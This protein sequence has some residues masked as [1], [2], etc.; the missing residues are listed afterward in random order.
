MRPSPSAI[1]RYC[2]YG[3]HF[4]KPTKFVGSLP[5]LETLSR[6]RQGGHIHEQLQ[7][8]AQVVSKSYWRTSLAA[9]YP[10]AL[11]RALAKLVAAHLRD[12][13]PGGRLAG[14]HNVEW[15]FRWASTIC[16]C[17]MGYLFGA[18]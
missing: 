2:E 5:G 10:P 13:C 9:A 7:R 11:C 17:V 1:I 3:A 6:R 16:L 18:W 12:V 14:R 8:I 4:L 15:W